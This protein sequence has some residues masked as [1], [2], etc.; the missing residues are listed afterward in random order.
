MPAAAVTTG[1]L[2]AESRRGADGA[3]DEVYDVVGIGFGPSNLALAIAL[4]E[5]AC[6]PA[7]DRPVRAVFIER[8]DRFGWHPGMLIDGAN[9]QVSFLKDLVTMRDPTSDFSFLSYL[10]HVGRLPDFINQKNVYPSRIEFNAYL[11]WAAGRLRHRA[12]YGLE[13]VGASPV[14]RDGEVRYID[15]LARRAA[16]GC[17]LTYRTRNLV[18]AAGL[19]PRL[20]P[21]SLVSPR[22][23][24]S[25]GLLA[26]LRDVPADRVQTFVV[27]GAGQ[28]AAEVVE[29]VHR[30]FPLARVHSVF[31]R[32]GYSPSDDSPFVNGI[33]DPDTVDLFFSAPPEV[34]DQILGYHSN[35]NYSVVDID[36]INVLS[37]RSYEER[38]AGEQ[39]LIMRNLSRVVAARETSAGL[40]VQLQ[41]LPDASV[42][43]V[44]ADWLIYATGYRPRD[45]LAL[46]GEVGSYCKAG[47][48]QSLRV[49]RDHR[50]VTAEGMRCGI[51]LQGATE[52]T[53]GLSSTLLSTTAIRAGEIASA[54]I[55]DMDGAGVRETAEIYE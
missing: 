52:A 42:T 36:L 45:P 44:A 37:Q 30:R 33:F 53:H 29:Y 13:A 54:V 49:A 41:Y 38:V 18:V 47:P 22:A 32:Y 3:P 1:A 40:A 5:Q 34:K 35:T 39:R 24:H 2:A 17:V 28:S 15:V 31:S 50:V 21:D 16:D 55:A 8:Q 20:P 11:S 12:A 6:Q 7:P 46:L 51:Y 14:L 9:M 23:W 48:G 27:V 25:A 19:E 10:Q 26:R 4:E 43:S